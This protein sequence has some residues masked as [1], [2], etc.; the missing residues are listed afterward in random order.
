MR[1][2]L[3]FGF[4][5]AATSASHFCHFP[6]SPELVYEVIKGTGEENVLF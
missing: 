3:L 4:Y 5:Y 2:R 1:L 6:W